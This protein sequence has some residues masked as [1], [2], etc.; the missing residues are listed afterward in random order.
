MYNNRAW[1]EKHSMTDFTHLKQRFLE[2]PGP[3]PK[4]EKDKMA[5]DSSI[6]SQLS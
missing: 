4:R 2:K 3:V 6:V 1:G 5:K